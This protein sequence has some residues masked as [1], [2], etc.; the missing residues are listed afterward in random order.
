MKIYGKEYPNQN[1]EQMAKIQKNA[2]KYKKY[3]FPSGEVRNVQGY[4]PFALD[5]L[6]SKG[7]KEEQIKTDRSE[8]DSIEYE[9]NGKKKTYFPDIYI[10]H[11]NKIIEVK[12]GWTYKCKEDNIK[13]KADATRAKGYDYEIWIYDAKGNKTIV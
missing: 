11:E 13:Q 6:I 3:T 12:S 10:P 4:E 1:Q 9:V 5:E 7:Y 2:K 8:V